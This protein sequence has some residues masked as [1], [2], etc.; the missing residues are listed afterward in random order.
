M[1]LFEYLPQLMIAYDGQD[2]FANL[3]HVKKAKQDTNYYCPCCGG[4]VKPRALNST[5]E[6]VLKKVN[7]TFFVRIGYLKKGVNFT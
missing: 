5:K 4:I 6:H 7:Y 3:I 2:E 1:E